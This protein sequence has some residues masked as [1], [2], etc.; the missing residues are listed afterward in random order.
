MPTTEEDIKM[1][2]VCNKCNGE[3]PLIF[4]HKNKV[5]KDGYHGMCKDCRSKHDNWNSRNKEHCSLMAK[6]RYEK[7]KT[8]IIKRAADWY[9]DNKDRR[10]QA[11]KI[12]KVNN[13]EKVRLYMEVHDIKR[14]G[15][16]NDNYVRS[17]FVQKTNI[18]RKDV[19]QELIEL[20]R[21]QI[22]IT[23][24]IRNKNVINNY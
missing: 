9:T 2:K 21:I 16:L 15:G 1:N 8:V 20:K 6:K 19:P 5:A 3:K 22:L 23:R 17:L 11:N 7:D 10:I 4:Y 24:E 18:K 13:P 14:R 12:W